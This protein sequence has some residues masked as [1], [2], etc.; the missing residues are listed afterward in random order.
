MEGEFLKIGLISIV[1][2]INNA[3][4][5][6]LLLPV[7]SHERKRSI[8]ILLAFLLAI[9]QVCL[10]A[11]VSAMLHNIFLK[12]SCEYRQAGDV[13]ISISVYIDE[14]HVDVRRFVL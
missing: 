13:T 4:L 7:L 1:T 11:S 8:L 12:R 10:V 9:S 5:A 2:T 3:L 14:Q 6:G